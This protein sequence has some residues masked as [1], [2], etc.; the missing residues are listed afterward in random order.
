M[1]W[2]KE[3]ARHSLASKGIKSK[4]YWQK[5]YPELVKKFPGE[6]PRITDDFVRFRQADPSKFSK[7]RTKAVSPGKQVILGKS[8]E[9]GEFELQ[10]VVISKNVRRDS[11][12]FRVVQDGRNLGYVKDF[13]NFNNSRHVPGFNPRAQ[14]TVV[15][16]DKGNVAFESKIVGDSQ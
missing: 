9:T 13:S 4:K 15:Y 6:N 3:S 5:E 11:A 7:F 12:A 10:S 2:Y 16:D 1:A 8:K 14:R